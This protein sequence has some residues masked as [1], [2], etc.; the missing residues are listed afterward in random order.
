VPVIA[1]IAV[2]AIGL[3]AIYVIVNQLG[4]HVAMKPFFAVTGLMLYYMAFVFAG[5]GI[6]ELQGAGAIPL[7]VIEAAPRIPVLG[8]YPT[9]ES[10]LVQGVL[11]V[12]AVVAAVWALRPRASGAPSQS[13]LL[14]S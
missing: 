9:L 5:K 2:G 14:R 8:V 7:T 11:L 3:V 10:L 13:D 4:L 12:L 1:G 6:A